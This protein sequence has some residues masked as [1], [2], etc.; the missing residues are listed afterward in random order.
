MSS[1]DEN[2]NSDEYTNNYR[3]PE[4]HDLLKHRDTSPKEYDHYSKL[5][6]KQLS[7]TLVQLRPFVVRFSS[8]KAAVY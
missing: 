5:R 6:V 3:K 4:P 8:C 7:D 1:S 2:T